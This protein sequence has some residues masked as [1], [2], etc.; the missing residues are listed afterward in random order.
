MLNKDNKNQLA[1]VG[2]AQRLSELTHISRE[3]AFMCGGNVEIWELETEGKQLVIDMIRGPERSCGRHRAEVLAIMQLHWRCAFPASGHKCFLAQLLK[4]HPRAPGLWVGLMRRP[5][6]ERLRVSQNS[7]R[8]PSCALPHLT[9]SRPA[10]WI[11]GD[12]GK[13]SWRSRA[14]AVPG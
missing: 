1:A 14:S 3:L 8:L 6:L 10:P 5:M 2:A 9:P 12:P 11:L 7:F 13:G 4:H